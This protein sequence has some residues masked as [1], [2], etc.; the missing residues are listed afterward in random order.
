MW[1]TNFQLLRFLRPRRPV[2]TLGG[3]TALAGASALYGS[4]EIVMPHSGVGTQGLPFGWVLPMGFAVL[5]VGSQVSSMSSWEATAASHLNRRVVGLLLSL[6]LCAALLVGGIEWLSRGPGPAAQAE[7]GLLFWAGVSL[8]SSRMFGE[9]HCWL[10]PVATLFPVTYLSPDA[11][12]QPRWWDWTRAT[13]P[14]ATT[15]SLATAMLLL[16]VG[17]SIATPWRVAAVRHTIARGPTTVGAE[18]GS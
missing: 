6:F 12:G 14:D 3:F 10:L 13:P 5:A 1:L 11:F 2:G 15:W 8:L 4:F 9:R 17:A 16:G 7:R 18:L